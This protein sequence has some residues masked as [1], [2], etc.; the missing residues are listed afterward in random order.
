MSTN[1]THSL[2]SLAKDGT[3]EQCSIAGILSRGSH[4]QPWALQANALPTKLRRP[5][6]VDSSILLGYTTSIFLKQRAT[7]RVVLPVAERLLYWPLANYKNHKSDA[8][9]MQKA[10]FYFGLKES[11]HTYE[12]CYRKFYTWKYIESHPKFCDLL[13]LRKIKGNIIKLSIIKSS[14][15]VTVW[16]QLA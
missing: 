16:I 1:G 2:T 5:V 7:C 6:K 10:L 9:A 4:P 15:I 12:L 11:E 14:I 3:C 8:I 13:K